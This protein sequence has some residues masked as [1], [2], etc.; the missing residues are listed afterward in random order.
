MKCPCYISIVQ[1]IAWDSNGTYHLIFRWY[2]ALWLRLIQ[3]QSLM[4]KEL[5]LKK[6]DPTWKAREENDTSQ[7]D[8]SI[9]HVKSSVHAGRPSMAFRTEHYL[10]RFRSHILCLQMFL[11]SVLF[12]DCFFQPKLILLSC[13]DPTLCYFWSLN[14]PSVIFFTEWCTLIVLEKQI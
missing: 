5:L 6:I 8:I 12:S 13:T 9:H 10:S 4:Q 3:T 1:N 2:S 7:E 11:D 14:Y